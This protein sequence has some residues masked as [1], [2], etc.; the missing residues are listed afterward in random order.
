MECIIK[1]V[2]RNQQDLDTDDSDA[3]IEENSPLKKLKRSIQNSIDTG[4]LSNELKIK[5]EKV[6][7]SITR[8]GS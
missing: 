5:R 7:R 8:L 6:V 2:N 1:V 3:E 4:N